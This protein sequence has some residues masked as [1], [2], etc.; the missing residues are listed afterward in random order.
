MRNN[1]NKSSKC[2]TD[3]G[4]TYISDRFALGG[5]Q[6]KM[7]IHL[8]HSKNH[9][10]KYDTLKAYEDRQKKKNTHTVGEI[11]ILSYLPLDHGRTCTLI[12]WT[13]R[14]TSDPQ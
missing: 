14:A 8:S 2:I 13:D 11:H 7:F 12:Y 3:S 5:T 9:T 4:F 1:K 6:C 10:Q